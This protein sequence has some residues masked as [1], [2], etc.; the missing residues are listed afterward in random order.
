MPAIEVA[1]RSKALACGNQ[2]TVAVSALGLVNRRIGD[3]YVSATSHARYN[4]RIGTR[5]SNHVKK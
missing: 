1:T 4:G 2:N 3:Q 5:F